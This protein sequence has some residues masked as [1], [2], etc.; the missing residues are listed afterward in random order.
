[1]GLSYFKVSVDLTSIHPGVFRPGGY[2]CRVRGNSRKGFCAGSVRVIWIC[3]LLAVAS[4]EARADLLHLAQGDELTVRFSIPNWSSTNPVDMPVMVG[5]QLVGPSPGGLA[6]VAIPGSTAQYYSGILLQGWIESVGGSTSS[7]LFNADA[8]RLGLTA[9]SLVAEARYGGGTF[10]D[11][12]AYLSQTLAQSLF[13]TSGQAVFLLKNLGS[14]LT[15][16]LGSNFSLRNA[17]VEPIQ[18]AGYSQISGSTQQISV[19]S[20]V[21]EPALWGTAA[22]AFLVLFSMRKRLAPAPAPVP[23][24]RRRG[25]EN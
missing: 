25:P 12:E 15:L 14:P 10:I 23:I 3:W 13:G 11:A 7:P 16:G 1:M 20:P 4:A 24:D 9:G 2:C 18:T 17:V 21:P 19:A 8:Q 22:L 6:P 5:L